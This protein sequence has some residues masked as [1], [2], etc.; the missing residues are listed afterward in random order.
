MTLIILFLRKDDDDVEWMFEFTT[1]IE[2]VFI[3]LYN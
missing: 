2:R 1:R 3:H